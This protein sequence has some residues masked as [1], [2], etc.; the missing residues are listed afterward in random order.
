MK[1]IPWLRQVA[2]HHYVEANTPC[3][4][5][6]TAFRAAFGIYPRKYR[7]E[8]NYPIDDYEL[9]KYYKKLNYSVNHHYAGEEDLKKVQVFISMIN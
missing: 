3:N 8:M 9:V 6:R 5:L 4:P 1:R 2:A 7:K